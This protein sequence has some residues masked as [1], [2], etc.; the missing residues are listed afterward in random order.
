MKRI[1]VYSI[2]VMA[3]FFLLLGG[4]K[5]VVS[6]TL[7]LR[8]AQPSPKRGSEVVW[9]KWFTAELERRTSGRVKATVFWGGSLA[10]LK[11]G[12]E[13]VK[14]NLA[15]VAWVA[16]A[17]TPKFGSLQTAPTAAGL[18]SP[19]PSPVFL[20]KQWLK[21]NDENPALYEEFATMNMVPFI[22]R[23]Y[24][25]YWTFS[26]KP[27]RSL[28]DYEGVKVRAV[29]EIQQI[30][31]KAIGAVPIF[32]SFSEVYGALQKGIIH[33]VASSP[34]TAN[35]YKVQEV[36][37]YVIRHDIMGAWANWCINIKTLKKMSWLDQKT[38][39]QLGRE[40]SIKIA[41]I[42]EK[43][44]K[45]LIGVFQK[46]GLEI[47]P[48]SKIDQKI[49]SS[50]PQLTEFTENY[51]RESEAKGLPARDIIKRYLGYLKK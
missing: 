19:D 42:N 40:A 35:R 7:N 50:K 37:K 21:V 36:T 1:R 29:T 3:L 43:E 33:A 22:F 12:A 23:W 41:E 6:E 13:A 46:A 38:L 47:I 11:E 30:A 8:W 48:F 2:V 32:L 26:N 20:T 25:V 45:R 16:N 51:I 27:I 44:R 28:A 17:Y 4:V 34:D 31:F 14:S 24:D 49:W 15:D 10:S 39:F 5:P 9:M 18:F